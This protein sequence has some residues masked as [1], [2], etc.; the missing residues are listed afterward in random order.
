MCVFVCAHAFAPD[1]ERCYFYAAIS[2][3]VLRQTSIKQFH[4]GNLCINAIT[5]LDISK[6]TVTQNRAGKHLPTCSSFSCCIMAGITNG[7]GYSQARH[8]QS[9]GG[10]GT[11]K[12]VEFQWEKRNFSCW[13]LWFRDVTQITL[14]S[15][16]EKLM[17]P[18]KGEKCI[19]L[20][21]ARAF[22]LREGLSL[23]LLESWLK[24]LLTAYE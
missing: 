12:A 18:S 11:M 2:C 8:K 19:L 10:A 7:S 17:P 15:S 21:R 1:K 20:V 23:F 3:P 5:G 4:I 24:Q 6:L 22:I 9:L 16:P 13:H 14:K